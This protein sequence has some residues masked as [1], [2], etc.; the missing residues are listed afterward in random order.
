MGRLAT[1]GLRPHLDPAPPSARPPLRV[2]THLPDQG[3]RL[4]VRVCAR[5]PADHGA[6]DG[7]G[8]EPVRAPHR[9]VVCTR[10]RARAPD[11][12]HVRT[13]TSTR[14]D[15]RRPGVRHVRVPAVPVRVLAT[16]VRVQKKSGEGGPVRPARPPGAER[17]AGRRPPH[18][19]GPGGG[20]G[21]P[22]IL[23]YSRCGA[24]RPPIPQGRSGERETDRL[25]E[26]RARERRE[27]QRAQQER[28]RAE[29]GGGR[30]R[31]P[32]EAAAG[33]C[34]SVSFVRVMQEHFRAVP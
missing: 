31:L 1:T 23:S 15:T 18:G 32:S 7:D 34:E 3:M 33:S 4:C 25:T 9:R 27:R 30:V 22:L 19:R 20:G 14:T 26:R 8:L 13:R 16:P 28:T 29:R 12:A 6:H 2:H 10:A 21:G 11:R 17:R 5:A 24:I